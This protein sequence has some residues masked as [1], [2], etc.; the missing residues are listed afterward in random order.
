MID[1]HCH[2]LHGID[3]GAKIM[4]DSLKMAK[5]AVSEGIDTI[6]A[7]PHHQ[8]GKYINEKND[9]VPRVSALNDYLLQENV[10]LTILP[11]QEVRIYGELIGDYRDGKILTLNQTN[12]YIFIELPS[13]Q[14]PRFTEQL[15]YDIQ[16]EG[17]IPIIVHPERNSCLIENPNILYNLVNTGAMTQIT[18]SSLTG[19]FGNKIKK[20]SWDL[21]NANLTHMVASDA[22]NLSGRN[23]HMQEACEWIASEF[24]IDTLYMFY[25]NAESIVNGYACFKDTPEKVRKKKFLGIF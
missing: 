1:L 12:K 11:G 4:E 23:F 5:Q 16:I 9:I 6:V 14:V 22:H 7:T 20:F 21:I 10:P 19:R 13:S 24:G 17:L 8:N 25:E 2:I 3:D 18:A 15:L